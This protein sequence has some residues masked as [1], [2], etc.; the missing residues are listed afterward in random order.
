MRIPALLLSLTLLTTSAR[1]ADPDFLPGVTRIVF[2]GDSI[3]YS[4]QYV[5]LFEAFLFTH[6]PQRVFEVIDCGLS[7]ETVSGLSEVGHA[8]GKFP[9]P[10]LHERL[11]RVLAKAK[12]QLIFACYGM[13]DGI[14]KP[15]DDVRALR[16]QEGVRKLREKAKAAGAEVIHLTPPV[17]DPVPISGKVAPA[18]Q[19]SASAPYEGYDDVLTRYSDWLIAQRA[20]GWRVIDI[21]TPMKAAIAKQRETEVSFTFAKDGVHANAEGHA[22]IAATLLAALDPVRAEKF[23]ATP[24]SAELMTL[25]RKRG[26][27]L[28]DAWLKDIGHLRPGTAQNALPLAEAQTQAAGIERQIREKAPAR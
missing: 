5:D 7:S 2:L 17:F 28:T 8:G 20:A 19:E 27:L 14:Y 22:L 24:P 21:H 23:K 25:I 3:T 16:F 4:G 10:D 11:D 18:G 15:Y 13:N 9:R 6:F 1:A 12:P 26:R